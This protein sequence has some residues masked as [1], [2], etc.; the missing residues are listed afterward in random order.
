[1]SKKV[2]LSK[3]KELNVPEL[4]EAVKPDPSIEAMTKEE[5]IAYFELPADANKEDLDNKFWK[6]GKVYQ[7]KKDEQKLADIA[8]AYN[9]ATGERDRLEAEK[10][11]EET[12]KR[13]LGKTKKQWQVFWHY[14]WPKFVLG[15]AI[16][17][18]LISFLQV[19]ILAPK[20]D[21]RVAAI[22]NF[23][24][25]T[26]TMYEYLVNKEL[27]N[28]PDVDVA[29][30]GS[31]ES[32]IADAL[33]SMNSEERSVGLMEV[34]P[35]ILVFD[36]PNAPVYVNAGNMQPLDDVYEQMKATWT[37]EQL[38]YIQPYVYSKARFYEEYADSL[39]EMYQEDLEQPTEED[40]VEHVYGF[41]LTD[42]V[43]QL[44]LGFTVNWK[45]GDQSIIFGVNAAGDDI[46]RAKSVLTAM[47][48]D[49]ES[50]R[51]AY[52]TE[53]PYMESST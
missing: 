34:H 41:I 40:Y 3:E 47:L 37:P 38:S 31:D 5:A 32:N 6:L 13:Y 49:M 39:P 24:L 17:V 14:E 8:C 19:F 16:L 20:T 52:L 15:L 27:C 50:V 42:R 44:A 35:D 25:N 10:K 18:G 45:D 33:A 48:G 30:V 21:F 11:E 23:Q 22:G 1:M 12:A 28:E 2:K 7:A 53:Y 26:D 29:T 4:K 9:I 43:D 51:S 46:D 36:A